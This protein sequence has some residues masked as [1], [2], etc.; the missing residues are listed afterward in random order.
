MAHVTQK[1][2]KL[3]LRIRRLRG[4]L[5]AAGRAIETEEACTTVLQTLV[6]CRGALN[7]LIGEVIEDHVR[8]HVVNPDKNPRSKQAQGARELIDVLKTYLK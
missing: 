8:Y 3:L 6:A 1:R 4:Q 5:D 7:S 2:D